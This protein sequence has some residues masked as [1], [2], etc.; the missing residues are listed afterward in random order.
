MQSEAYSGGIWGLSPPGPVKSIDF[1]GFQ[2][3]WKE[4]KIKSPL[5]KFLNT[6]MQSI[7]GL[8]RGRLLGLSPPVPVK[9][10]DLWGFHAPKGAEPPPSLE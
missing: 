8:F 5:D 3:P 6:P 9:S 2:A 1:R 4:K 10:I 7:I